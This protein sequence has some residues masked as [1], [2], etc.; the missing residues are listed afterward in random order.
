MPLPFP[1]LRL[2]ALLLG[3][4]ALSG[5][6]SIGPPGDA[7]VAAINRLTQPHTGQPLAA[8][9]LSPEALAERLREPLGADA[10]VQ[11]ALQ[12]SRALQARLARLGVTAAEVDAA[13]RLP[14]PGFSFSRLRR[15]DEVELERGW[16]ISLARLLTLPLVQ[17]AEQRRLQAEQQLAAA[18][19]LALAADTRRAWV[20][21]VAAEA[22]LSYRRQVLEAGDAG[23]ELA[24][25]MQAAGNF[26]ALAHAREQAFA[27]DARLGLA[28]TESQRLAAR[29]RLV[30]LLGLSSVDAAALQLPER[31]P[32]L[33]AAPRELADAE[34][35][36]LSQRL[37]VQAAR[38]RLEQASRQLEAGRI[39][40]FVSMLELGVVRNSSN[41]AP[42]QRGWEV[43]LELPLF[44]SGPLPRAQALARE[45]A[46]DAADTGI[47]AHSE[48]REAHGRYRGAFDIARQH[49]DE[50]L[51]LAQ[52]ISQEQLLRYNAML[53]GVF[54]LLA[55]ARSQVAA[56]AAAQD[57]LRDFWLAQADLDQT[58]LGRVTSSGSPALPQAG[59]AAAAPAAA[60]H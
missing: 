3:A 29:E 49:R 44:G 31:L 50:L 43:T 8:E 4:L 28:R 17:R 22:A 30:R 21:A 32:E 37:D 40:R 45:A 23:A 2:P 56:V 16:H 1:L 10:A 33:P 46:Y 18:D 35:L 27:A 26:N 24:K 15:G 6:A 38:L 11:L 54:E 57:A 47:R 55:D 39:N 42:T 12:N 5:C 19:V 20:V 34:T 53:I 14:N 52:R 9:P 25:R 7:D 36:A 41:E 60:A 59:S 51:P 13:S 58:L 48:V